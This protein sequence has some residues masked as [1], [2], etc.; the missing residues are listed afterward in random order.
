MTEMTTAELIAAREE[1]ERAAATILGRMLFEFSRLDVATGLLLVWTEGGRKLDELTTQI[2]DYTFHKKLE[3]LGE[4]V[5]RKFKQ[6]SEAHSSYS[7]WLRDAHDMRT[8]RNSLVHGRWDVG[9]NPP[10]TINVTGLPTSPDQTAVSYSLRS[11]EDILNAMAGLQAGLQKL[12]K[13][14]PV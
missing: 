12:R 13:Q 7:Q 5:D 1:L 4:L 2:S 9:G 3:F 8:T 10:Q 6:G 11:L 14:W